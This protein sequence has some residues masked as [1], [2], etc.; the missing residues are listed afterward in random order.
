M[1]LN[2]KRSSRA[3]MTRKASSS[4]KLR[5]VARM[6]KRK[7]PMNSRIVT[8]KL[9]PW[10]KKRTRKSLSGQLKTRPGK[11]MARSR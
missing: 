5:A 10:L 1:R 6:R 11:S 4:G 8:R 9:K 3:I 2:K 7:P